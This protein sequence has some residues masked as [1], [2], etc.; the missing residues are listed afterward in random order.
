MTRK[1][2]PSPL[3]VDILCPPPNPLDI[4][5]LLDAACNASPLPAAQIARLAGVDPGNLSRARRN[6]NARP[7]LAR[8]V[9]AALGVNVA[10]V[11]PPRPAVGAS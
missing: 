6:P 3:L 7:A 4:G 8:K 2:K 11:T 5:A 9:L 10:L 1:A